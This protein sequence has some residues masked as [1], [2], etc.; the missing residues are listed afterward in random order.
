[1]FIQD[2]DFF[3]SRI[4]DPGVKKVRYRTG[5]RIWIRNTGFPV[6]WLG[7]FTLG[8]GGGGGGGGGFVSEKKRFKRIHSKVNTNNNKIEKEKNKLCFFLPSLLE[9]LSVGPFLP[10]PVPLNS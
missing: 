7:V 8:G 5:S 6:I 4:P 10:L 2:L 3:P 1:M 9:V